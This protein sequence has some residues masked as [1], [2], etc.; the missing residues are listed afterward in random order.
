MKVPMV[1]SVGSVFMDAGVVVEAGT[2]HEVLT[3]P[4]V[5]VKGAV[6]VLSSAERVP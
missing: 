4:G 1:D 3:N 5:P 2:P 6:N